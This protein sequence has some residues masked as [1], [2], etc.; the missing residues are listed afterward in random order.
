[1]IFKIR[2]H[3]QELY[4]ALLHLSRNL[5][6]Y[7]KIKLKDVFE[8]RIY[9]MFI[10]F[11]IIL[12]IYKNKQITFP[13]NSY[14]DLFYCI[15]NNLRE[16]G[17]G[18]VAVNKKMKELNKFFYDILLKINSDKERFKINHKLVIKYFE[19]LNDIKEMKYK[20]FDDYFMKF[21]NFCFDIEAKIMLKET[22]N[23]KIE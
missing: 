6:F 17:L 10:H 19:E 11:S 14:D 4:N 21:Y 18:D 20:Y 15:E 5:Y 12:I 2:K 13:Q 7:N 3:N 8:T 1:M 9:L 23:F 16:I 22:L